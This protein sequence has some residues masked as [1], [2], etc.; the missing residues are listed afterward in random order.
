MKAMRFELA[1]EYLVMAA[2]L[3]EIKSRMLLPR[4]QEDEE[5][6]GDPRAELIAGCSNMSVSKGRRGFDELPALERDTFDAGWSCLSLKCR[7]RI[8]MGV[9]RGIDG[10]G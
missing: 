1:A 2:T 10:I 8:L 4:R 9:E 3:A 6:E 7:K 5:D